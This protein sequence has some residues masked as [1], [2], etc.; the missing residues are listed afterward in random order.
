MDQLLATTSNKMTKAITILTQDLG[1]IRAGRANP[2]LVD[3]V[4][5][6]VYGGSQELSVA[7]LAT[8]A[9]SDATTMTV[10]PF[11][12]SI[13]D[14]LERGLQQANLGLSISQDGETI[15]IVVPPMTEERRQEFTKLAK[16]KTEGVRIM[17][18]Q[19]RQD[20]V[21]DIRKLYQAK[22]IG[23]DE[24]FRLEKEIQKKTDEC[25]E[26]AESLLDAKTK[27]LNSM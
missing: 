5:I 13:V 1:T 24:K 19:I 23:E 11:D 21:N 6:K 8:I 16:T 12:I 15:R 3:H 2:S 22:E 10:T 7:E 9:T 20:A 27:E 17:I 14:E 25:M 18:R 26:E 4:R